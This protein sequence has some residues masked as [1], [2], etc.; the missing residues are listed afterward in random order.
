MIIANPDDDVVRLIY[1]DWLEE[2]GT[3]VERDRA[4]F[5][6]LQIELEGVEDDDHRRAIVAECNQSIDRHW[7]TWTYGFQANSA[8]AYYYKNVYKRGFLPYMCL[9]EEDLEDPT[10]DALLAH[11]PITHF[12]LRRIDTIPDTIVQWKHLPRVRQLSFS[13]GGDKVKALLRS[14]LLTGLHDLEAGGL[15]EEDI[16]LIAS[17]PRF[18]GLRRLVFRY[19]DLGDRA[20][21]LA[22]QSRTLSCLTAFDYGCSRTTIAALEAVADSPL[23]SRLKFIGLRQDEPGEE[24]MAGIRAAELLAGFR[25]LEGIDLAGLQIGD[26][27]AEILARSSLLTELKVLQ[28]GQNGLGLRG[29]TALLSSPYLTKV[30][31]LDLSKNRP[32]NDWIAALASAGPRRLRKLTLED[33]QL[34]GQAAVLLAYAVALEGV[35]E[36]SLRWNSIGDQGAVALAGSARLTHLR[37]LGL[38]S[39]DIGDQGAIALAES[40]TLKRLEGFGGLGLA[41][42]RYTTKAARRLRKRFDY[43][44][45]SY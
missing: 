30:E 37:K 39:C 4:R 7:Q 26:E 13:G 21:E 29:V 38:G 19:S 43:D 22:A 36:L 44:P 24:P 28:L 12:F 16:A 1:A 8:D 2:N 41:H 17:D 6:R 18:A 3:A 10:L 27:G 33:N 14:P 35:R 34:D 9:D 32:G 31:E 15:A 5:I 45:S 42:N 11:E 40:A 23:A 20:V 25:C